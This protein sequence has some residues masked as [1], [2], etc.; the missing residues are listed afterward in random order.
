[1]TT[2][3]AFFDKLLRIPSITQDVAACNRAVDAMRESL[4]AR[5]LFCTTESL[6]ERQFLCAA[7]APGKVHDYLFNAHLD[8]VPAPER[9]FE[10]RAEGG[11]IFGRGVSDCKGNA[12][13]IAQTLCALA[14]KAS[15]GA[16]FTTDEETGG[17]TTAEAVRLGY[18]AHKLIAVIDANPY[19]V[20]IAQKGIFNLWLKAGGKSVHSSRPWLGENAI[21]N[22]VDGYARLRAA[23]KVNAPGPDGDIWFDSFAPTICQAGTVHNRVPDEAKMLLNIRYTRYGDEDRIEKFVRE[24]S[25]LDTER[26]GIWPPF[27]CDENSPALAALKA[28]LERTWPDRPIGFTKMTGATDARHFAGMGVPIAILGC[29]GGEEHTDGEWLRT[30]SIGELAGMLSI[31]ILH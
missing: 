18:G 24:A 3:T 25:G 21:D 4:E 19:T 26:H 1:M 5:G 30:D 10:P 15:A 12:V 6:G 22:L 31:F 23:W 20:T 29:D 14:G 17:D 7:T 16:V 11:K 13:A 8:V 2:D 9:M 28:A 27:C